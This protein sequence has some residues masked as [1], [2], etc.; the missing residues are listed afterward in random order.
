MR[1]RVALDVNADT[2]EADV[3]VRPCGRSLEGPPGLELLEAAGP[4][5][6][7]A[8]RELRHLAF[9]RGLP[10]GEAVSTTAGDLNARWLVHVAVPEYPVSGQRD[11]L[12]TAAYRSVLAVADDLGARTLWVPAFGTV[13]PYWPLS[14]A[15][16]LAFST[17]LNTITSVRELTLHVSSPAAVEIYLDALARQSGDNYPR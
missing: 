4:T 1:L 5:A 6:L 11:H 10:A 14:D 8:C 16:R 3:I 2:A 17:L 9:P 7:A 12:F 15:A 13:L